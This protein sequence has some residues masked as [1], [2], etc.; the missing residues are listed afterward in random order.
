MY[1]EGSIN[2]TRFCCTDDKPS[3]IAR[4]I[5]RRGPGASVLLC[6]ITALAVALFPGYAGAASVPGG[7]SGVLRVA[8]FGLGEV[9]TQ[10][11]DREAYQRRYQIVEAAG[12]VAGMQVAVIGAGGS[13]AVFMRLF[14]EK[15]GDSGTVYAAALSQVE[16]D[17]LLSGSRL[18]DA[19]NV[20]GI[21]GSA[22]ETGLPARSIDLAFLCNSY[23]RLEQPQAL[24]QSV[25]RALKPGGRLIV[26]DYRRIPGVS[27]VW[28]MGQVSAGESA[29]TAEI[30]AAGF[31]L[32]RSSD[33]LEFN[34]FL[35]FVPAGPSR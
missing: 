22:T 15:V 13:D 18:H 28:V 24:L 29:V 21:A 30:E 35:D 16:I 27:P 20:A 8:A 3:F 32:V 1:E 19:A 17:A 2:R 4:R 26:I 25:G 23:H 14:S 11:P 6:G 12:V 9:G 34:Y 33:L 31:R 7:D 5:H 10:N